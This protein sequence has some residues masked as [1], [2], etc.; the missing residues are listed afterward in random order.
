MS[1]KPIEFKLKKLGQ[2]LERFL[3]A[4]LIS[5]DNPLAI[6][7]TIQRFEFCFELIW[8]TLRA[9]I[10]AGGGQVMTHKHAFQMGYRAGWIDNEQ[11]W[12]AMLKDRNV[13]SHT[14]REEDA[15]AVYE[16]TKAYY[17]E[18][19]RVYAVLAQALAEGT[20]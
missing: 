2:A 5:R 17:D 13:L 8:K 1:E 11:I 3:E 9:V 20:L 14:Y 4:L 16:R 10:E 12:L 7:G 19:K 18:M 6:D 15:I